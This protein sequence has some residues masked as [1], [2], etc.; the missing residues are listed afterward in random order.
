[1]LIIF[2]SFPDLILASISQ[3]DHEASFNENLQY[4]IGQST[5]DTFYHSHNLLHKLPISFPAFESNFYFSENK[6]M[7]K[8]LFAFFTFST[9]KTTN[10]NALILTFY[11]CVQCNILVDFSPLNRERSVLQDC[12]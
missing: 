11:Q 6:S 7:P 8:M 3:P 5:L 10:E 12:F 9:L 1:M 2:N 4:K